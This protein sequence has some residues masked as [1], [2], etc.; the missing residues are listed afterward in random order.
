MKKSLIVLC[1]LLNFFCTY[2]SF[3]QDSLVTKLAKANKSSFLPE[4]NSFSGSGWTKIKQK[5]NASND[6]LIGEDH[7]TNEIP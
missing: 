4:G 7:F 6:V 1:V 2:D 5:V 3:A